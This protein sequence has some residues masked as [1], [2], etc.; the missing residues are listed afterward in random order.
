M[1]TVKQITDNKYLNLKE[2]KDPSNH[3]R[4]YQFAERAGKDSV[5]FIC[6]DINYGDF[7][8]NKEFKPPINSFLLGAFGGSLDKDKTHSEIVIDEVK[9][10]AG[11]TVIKKDVHC[12]G[13]VMV[14]TQMNQ[15]CY[16]FL[17]E[18]DKTKQE[19]REPENAIEAMAKT[20]W[21]T[22]DSDKIPILNDWKPITIIAMAQAKKIIP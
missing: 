18:V 1:R 19:D 13:K 17:V 22:W 4:Q 20:E 7:L 9:E 12:V 3:V 11:F 10:E 16:L 8:L 21:V 5:A 2:V 6:W 14:S 15:F